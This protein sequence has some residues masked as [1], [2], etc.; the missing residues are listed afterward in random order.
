MKMSNVLET[1]DPQVQSEDGTLI[2]AASAGRSA[3]Q[4]PAI[5][6]VPGFSSSSL[7]FRKQFQEGKLLKKYCLVSGL[8]NS[9]RS[10]ISLMLVTELVIG[11]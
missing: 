5:V 11:Y 6:F 10:L 3:D 8:G 7:T 9:R 4:A 1:T 2:W